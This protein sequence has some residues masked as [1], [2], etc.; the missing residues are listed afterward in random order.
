MTRAAA[1]LLLPLCLLRAETAQDRGKRVV[2]EAVN[3][4]G[5]DNFLN[6]NDRVETGRAY[7]FYRE[8]LSGLSIA[9]IYTRYLPVKKPGE[10]AVRERQ[11]FG[12]K[13]DFGVLLMEDG[14][15]WDV[16]FRGA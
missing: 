8:R 1:A 3:A 14:E 9:T 16:T 10:L 5:G 4:L 15:G 13:Q 12:K 7:S 2:M 11:M 6:M